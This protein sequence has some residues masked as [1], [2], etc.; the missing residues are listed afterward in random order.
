M[1]K[2][3][4]SLKEIEIDERNCYHKWRNIPNGIC[5]AL[6]LNMFTGIFYK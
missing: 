4:L 6:K 2:K 5:C 1:L 3:A